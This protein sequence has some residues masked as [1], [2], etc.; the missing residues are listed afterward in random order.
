VEGALL[1]IGETGKA[2]LYD[3]DLPHSELKNSLSA[4]ADSK[5]NEK[6]IDPNTVRTDFHF[7][8]LKPWITAHK[9]LKMDPAY[10]V[11]C[12]FFTFGKVYITATN[13]G[14]VKLWDNLELRCLGT[15]NSKGWDPSMLIKHL[16]SR[17]KTDSDA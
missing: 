8:V 17:I 10:V 2:Q 13:T 9:I 16:G 1:V 3:I 15:V 6:Y 5:N 12:K 4:M 11:S 14:E 7:E